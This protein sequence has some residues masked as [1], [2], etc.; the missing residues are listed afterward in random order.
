MIQGLICK[1]TRARGKG[2]AP[3]CIAGFWGV[4]GASGGDIWEK[5]NGEGQPLSE[6]G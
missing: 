2:R 3:F 5:K 6:F 4:A 1:T